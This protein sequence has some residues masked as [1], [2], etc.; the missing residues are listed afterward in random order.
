MKLYINSS[1]SAYDFRH[2]YSVKSTSGN[3]YQVIAEGSVEDDSLR[4]RISRA[5]S[6][7]RKIYAYGI[8]GQQI[9][10]CIEVW[11]QGKIQI[12][13][14]FGSFIESN[15][16]DAESYLDELAFRAVELTDKVNESLE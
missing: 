13:E 10:G 8:V 3:R 1:N 16:K 11:Y 12:S 9:P 15:F 6:N 5:E 14:K 4:L 2:Y 7:G